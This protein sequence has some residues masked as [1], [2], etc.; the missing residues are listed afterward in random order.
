MLQNCLGQMNSKE[1]DVQNLQ[2]KLD[3]LAIVIRHLV[4]Q[5]N[6]STIFCEAVKNFPF[7]E[8]LLDGLSE[9]LKLSLLEQIGLGLALTN[10]E[11]LQWQQHGKELMLSVFHLYHNILM[12]NRGIW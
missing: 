9:V 8:A 4:Q 10:A 2:L 7:N 11:D 6:F 3:L 12:K 5:P 1:G